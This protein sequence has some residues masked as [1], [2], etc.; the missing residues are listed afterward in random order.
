MRP[1][2]E[3]EGKYVAARMKKKADYLCDK[4]LGDLRHLFDEDVEIDKRESLVFIT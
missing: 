1:R 3:E 4:L 2:E